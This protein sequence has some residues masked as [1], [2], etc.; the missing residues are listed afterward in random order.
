MD[1]DS[2]TK[3][4]TLGLCLFVLLFPAL[5][6]AAAL[7]DYYLSRLAPKT[8][9]VQLLTS[10]E[11]AGAAAGQA[12]HCLTPLLRSL[13]RDW[14]KLELTTQKTLA[15][16]V[17]RPILA[18]MASFPSPAGHFTIH[19]ATSG[20]DAPDLSD[21]DQDQI[22]EWVEKVAEVFEQVYQREVVEMGYLPPPG[23]RYDV[24]LTDLVQEQAYG[25]TN[26]E[27]SGP[28]TSVASYI[29]IDKAFTDRIF[30]AYPP[31]E[32]LQA[33]AAHEYHHAIQFGYNYYFDIWYAEATAT[34]IEDEV[35]DA[36]NQLYAYLP[37]YLSGSS[38][39]SLNAPI[40]GASEYGRWIFNRQLAESHTP[41]V[42]RDIWATVGAMPAPTDGSD[43][44][45]APVIDAALA[46]RGSSLRSAFL[47]M[48]RNLYQGGWTSHTGDLD[49]IPSVA[50]VATFSSYPLSAATAAASVVALPHY[51]FAYYRFLPSASAPANLKIVLSSVANGTDVVA[52]RKESSGAIT[53][54]ALD[55]QTMSIT[56]PSF[57]SPQT[58]EVQ[59][60]V[61][62]GGN[63]DGVQ[64]GFETVSSHT[65]TL[66]FAGT[67]GG[68]VNG[69]VSCTKGTSCAPAQ[70]ATG[71]TV[72]LLASPDANSLFGG[73]SGACT[74]SGTGCT[75]TMNGDK[76]VSASFSAAPRLKILGGAGYNL[77]SEAYAAA[78]DGAV[79]QAR[80]LLFDD[81]ALTFSRPVSVSLKGGYDAGFTAR[82]GQTGIMGKLTIRD[83]TVRV[84][85]VLLR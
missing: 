82:S 80:Q 72:T 68:S 40:N 73:W 7:D 70:F 54:Y 76:S 48:A 85:R 47:S 19:Y 51:T 77:F 65:L 26:A 37:S 66:S 74:G 34:W 24:Y 58:T 38:S 11:H 75:V 64:V 13:K 56:V 3:P 39:I 78:A 81:G 84:D 8:K 17:S 63:S 33:T 28:G 61:S 60:L 6:R 83:G 20:S 29:E 55:Q 62:N 31:Y 16:A 21:P 5:A 1:G 10:A 30:G 57:N 53:S 27:L 49:R 15:K 12:E 18:G 32:S 41:A 23:G 79:I 71:A 59:L 22:P 36:A 25:L 45:M 2:V 52:F 43:I 44:P 42:V 14:N 35:F 50:P 46:A 4:S 9:S 69:S 67:G